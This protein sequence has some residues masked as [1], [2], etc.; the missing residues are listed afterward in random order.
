ME[1][2]LRKFFLSI[3]LSIDD[4]FCRFIIFR[5]TDPHYM[6]Y[7]LHKITMTL[8]HTWLYS[9]YFAFDRPSSIFNSQS[10]IPH[11]DCY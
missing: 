9:Q 8:E 6:L 2:L 3:N 10:I 11:S 4:E 7:I 1:H 5:D